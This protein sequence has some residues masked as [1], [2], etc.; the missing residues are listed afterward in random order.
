[1]HTHTHAH[2][3]TNAF[4]LTQDAK[5]GQQKWG[6][7]ETNYQRNKGITTE[8]SLQEIE[9]AM[10][11][12]FENTT[13]SADRAGSGANKDGSKPGVSGSDTSS[14]TAGSL[15]A[16]PSRFGASSGGFSSSKIT[17]EKITF[18]AKGSQADAFLAQHTEKINASYRPK[19]NLL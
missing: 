8:Q 18:G 5:Y 9:A 15:G 1:V 7:F 10:K 2:I 6:L 11:G 19:H 17:N 4:V 12:A 3:H 14:A 16:T 13:S